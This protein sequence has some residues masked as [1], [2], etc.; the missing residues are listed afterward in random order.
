MAF[1]QLVCSNLRK[2]PQSKPQKSHHA[3]VPLNQNAFLHDQNKKTTAVV[4]AHSPTSKTRQNVEISAA[5]TDKTPQ[6]CQPKISV[7][8]DM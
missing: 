6:G 4:V 2:L 5:E 1:T 7:D 3:L 8:D